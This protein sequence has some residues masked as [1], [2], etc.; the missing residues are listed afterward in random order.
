MLYAIRQLRE[1]YMEHERCCG[2]I[3]PSAELLSRGGVRIIRGMSTKAGSWGSLGDSFPRNINTLASTHDSG[4]VIELINLRGDLFSQL[5][6][7][8]RMSCFNNEPSLIGGA[9]KHERRVIRLVPTYM[10]AHIYE[11][12]S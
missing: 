6:R 7:W 3:P 2:L 8:R 1:Q 11:L 12:L 10:G 5:Q 4:I 9:G